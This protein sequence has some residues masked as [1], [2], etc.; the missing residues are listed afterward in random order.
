MARIYHGKLKRSKAFRRYRHRLAAKDQSV[1]PTGVYCY[2]EKGVCPYLERNIKKEVL[3]G[4]QS[5]GHC[6]FLEAGDWMSLKG[7]PQGTFLLFDA[8]KECFIR[9]NDPE[10]ESNDPEYKEEQAS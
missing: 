4:Y 5:S 8:V 10:D 1:I 9:N 7:I 2:N 3:L 6:S